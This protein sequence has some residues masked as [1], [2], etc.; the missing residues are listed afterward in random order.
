MAN[1]DAIVQS[2]PGSINEG[3]L[4]KREYTFRFQD[5]IDAGTYADDDTY[6]AQIPVFAGEKVVNVGANLVTAFDDSGSGSTLTLV[7]G[8][9]ADADGYLTSAELHVDGTE[10]STVADTGAF[11]VGGSGARGKLY[12]SD[13]TIDIVLTSSSYNFG[14]LTQGEAVVTAYV[15]KFA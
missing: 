8:D 15:A 10:I 14:E 6:T 3:A 12:T 7:A 1:I 9:G 2:T 5:I 11:V 13:D 4:Q